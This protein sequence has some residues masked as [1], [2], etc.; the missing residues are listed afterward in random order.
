MSRLELG[1]R[2]WA[3]FDPANAD[4]R[5]YYRQFA[6]TNSWGQCPVRF[7]VLEDHG[8]LISMVQASLAK[9]Y[10]WREFSFQKQQ[11]MVDN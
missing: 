11:E 10:S 5:R 3:L 1:C 8:D 7:M 2:P 4:H 9:W 6:L